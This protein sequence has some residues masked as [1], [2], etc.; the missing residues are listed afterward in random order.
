M[1]ENAKYL[2][3]GKFLSRG[4]WCHPDRLPDNTELILMLKGEFTMMEDGIEYPLQA[5]DVLRLDAG[6]RHAGAA[7]TDCPISFYWVHF[8]GVERSDLPP[9][10][11]RPTSTAQAELLIRQLLHYGENP[12]YPSDCADALLKVLLSELSHVAPQTGGRQTVNTIVQWIKYN[13]GIPLRVSDVAAHFGYNEDYLNRLFKRFYPQGLKAYLDECRLQAIQH[14]LLHEDIS[15]QALAVK[16]GFSEYKYFLK[17]FK[18]HTGL[19]PTQYRKT[20]SDFY[21]NS[22]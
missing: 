6:L 16:H 18:Y 20:Y 21:L 19:S 8:V 11:F 15:L 4:T 14:D 5:G 17:F 22:K 13:E 7:P 10:H 9:K 3:G 2:F 1:Y 12:A